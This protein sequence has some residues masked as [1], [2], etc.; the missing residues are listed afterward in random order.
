MVADT[1]KLFQWQPIPYMRSKIFTFSSGDEMRFVIT[2]ACSSDDRLSDH[3]RQS[4]ETI[5]ALD[6]IQHRRLLI[7]WQL[8]SENESF[9]RQC[10][11]INMYTVK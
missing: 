8:P 2:F 9:I 11:L 7:S 3:Q 5:N 6:A 1:F 4:S 10:M